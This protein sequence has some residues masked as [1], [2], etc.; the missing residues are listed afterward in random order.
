MLRSHLV[1]ATLL[2]AAYS[3]ASTGP[4][5]NNH[6]ILGITRAATFEDIQYAYQKQV[7]KHTKTR[8]PLQLP[9]DWFV[10]IHHAYEAISNRDMQDDALRFVDYW[11]DVTQ[12]NDDMELRRFAEFQPDGSSRLRMIV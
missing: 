6:Q 11:G 3:V 10:E 1:V 12:L 7:Q 2:I 8:T 5:K 4:T 9:E